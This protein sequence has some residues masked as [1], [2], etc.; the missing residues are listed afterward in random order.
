VGEPLL[1]ADPLQ[2]LDLKR[3]DAGSVELSKIGLIGE[4]ELHLGTNLLGG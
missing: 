3:F 1:I 4:S 2:E